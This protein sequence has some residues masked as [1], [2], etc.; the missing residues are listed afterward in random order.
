MGDAY[1]GSS[2]RGPS[3]DEAAAWIG[4][5]RGPV[6][7]LVGAIGYLILGVA[8]LLLTPLLMFQVASPYKLSVGKFFCR[9][10]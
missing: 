6:S 7:R 3:I 10:N 5:D 1:L 9:R 8:Y 2:G 4:F